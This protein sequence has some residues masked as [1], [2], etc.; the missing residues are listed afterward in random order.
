MKYTVQVCDHCREALDTMLCEYDGIG[1]A[2]CSVCQPLLREYFAKFGRVSHI[3]SSV[4]FDGGTM[5][6]V[7]PH[8]DSHK[9]S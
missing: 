6:K 4:H 3:T 8:P 5:K 7:E 9:E 2:L 1:L